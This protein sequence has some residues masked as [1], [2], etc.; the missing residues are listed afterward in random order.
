[1]S[2]SEVHLDPCTV[3]SRKVLAALHLLHTPFTLENID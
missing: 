3:S 1:M 2:P